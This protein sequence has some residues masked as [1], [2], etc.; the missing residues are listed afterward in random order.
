MNYNII[1]T[2]DH[3]QEPRDLWTRRLSKEKWG[4]R[5]RKC[6]AC[7]MGATA[8]SSGTSRSSSTTGP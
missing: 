1:S 2:D 8:G 7:R 4:N 6:A 3:M 5:I